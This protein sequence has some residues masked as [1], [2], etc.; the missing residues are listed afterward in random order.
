MNIKELKASAPLADVYELSPEGRYMIVMATG[1]DRERDES[2]ARALT[3]MLKSAD[4]LAP[5]MIV[6]KPDEIRFFDFG[7]PEER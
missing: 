6:S 4:I 7:E 5:I 1:G 2:D 3:G